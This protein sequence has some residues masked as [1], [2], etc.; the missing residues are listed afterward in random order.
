MGANPN[1]VLCVYS[2]KRRLFFIESGACDSFGFFN[3]FFGCPPRFR[4]G[5]YYVALDGADFIKGKI[6]TL[7]GSF[8]DLH[9]KPDDSTDFA[10]EDYWRC[11]GA[12]PFTGS[13]FP[14]FRL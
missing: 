14:V 13:D 2:L 10:T 8:I 12:A 11:G 9:S 3:R 4:R 1:H 7:F 5:F 6:F